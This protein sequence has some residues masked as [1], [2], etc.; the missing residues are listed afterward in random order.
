VFDYMRY[1]TRRT[2][3]TTP[4]AIFG[5]NSIPVS[6]LTTVDLISQLF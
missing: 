2:P 3:A 6:D 1:I 4:D 5:P